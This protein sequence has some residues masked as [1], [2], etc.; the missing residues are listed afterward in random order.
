MMKH[1]IKRLIFAGAFSLA[2]GPSYVGSETLHYAGT[3][4]ALTMDPHA[5]NDFVTTAIFRQVYD[6]LTSL[7]LEMKTVPGLATSWE[8]TG[9]NTWR[10]T[11]RDGVTFHD[12]TPLTGE[13][14]AFSILRAKGSRFYSA[15]FGGITAVNVVEPLTVDVVSSAPDPIQPRKM[16]RM[17]IMSKTWAEA[18]KVTEI[19]DLGAGGAEAVSVRNANGTGPMKLVSHNQA[20]KTE[21]TR[22]E[23]Y[24]GEWAGNLDGAVYYPIGTDPT[25]MAALLSGEVQLIT[26]LP[27]QD[28]ERVTDAAGFKVT[29]TPQ[30]LWMQIE[31]DGTRDVALD[32]TDKNGNPLDANPFKDPRVRMAIAKTIDANLIADR[33]MRSHARVIGTA[34]VPGL[35]G[36][37]ADLDVRWPTDI[38]A[39]KTLLT[40]AGY[41]DGFATQLN[42]PL[43]RYV[44][45]DDICRAAASM[46]ARIGI[47]VKVN[48]MVWPEFARM[49]V[50]GP[51]SSF[52]LIG[53]GSNSWDTQD[54]F[55]AS[56]QTRNA[57][58][59]Q[60]FFNWALYSNPVVDEVT[61]KLPVTFDA[62][63]RTAL[64]RL[65]LETARDTVHAVYLHQ[66][67]LLWGMHDNVTAPMRGD[68]TLT[69]EN[70]VITPK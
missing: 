59:K 36:Y 23:A 61:K 33:I 45:T 3:T 56:M 54:T 13:D 66:P 52:H 5:T 55:T 62:E 49:L 32:T 26:D 64:Y 31:M 35:A 11:L 20:T 2:L 27:I 6:S 51:T 48:G 24:W 12:G 40:E 43:E 16:S 15:L 38:D 68:A 4:P 50:N 63:K 10:F 65:A 47:D 39:A 58:T 60:G 9:E 30:L 14:V 1:F 67:M 7:N 53:A 41:P 46:L 17:F 19:P 44:N 28:V 37:Q 70:V 22:N 69:L 8:Y 42:C 34:S 29:E 57:E 21:F 25:R 18:N